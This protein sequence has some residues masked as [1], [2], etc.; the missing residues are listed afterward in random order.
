M[1]PK[2]AESVCEIRAVAR[3]AASVLRGIRDGMRKEERMASVSMSRYAPQAYTG[4]Y[5]WMGRIWEVMN[6]KGFN[7]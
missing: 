6:N 3:S 1:I 5:T 7:R 4:S 2:D